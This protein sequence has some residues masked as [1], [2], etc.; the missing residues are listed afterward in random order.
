M[1]FSM[2]TIGGL[3]SQLASGLQGS[4]TANKSKTTTRRGSSNRFVMLFFLTLILVCLGLMAGMYLKVSIQDAYDKEYI[5]LGSELRLL[6]LKLSKEASAAAS[7]QPDA[8]MELTKARDEVRRI[9]KLLEEG[10]PIT[11]MPATPAKAQEALQG[12]QKAWYD[13]LRHIQFITRS[14]Q[15][16]RALRRDVERYRELSAE[17]RNELGELIDRLLASGASPSQVFLATRQLTLTERI[18]K[19]MNRALQ[20]GDKAIAAVNRF[21]R[22]ALLFVNSLEALLAGDKELGVQPIS[23]PT[24]KAIAQKLSAQS[25]RYTRLVN[26]VK[27]NAIA[28]FQVQAAAQAIARTSNLLVDKV[29]TLRDAYVTTIEERTLSTAL[30]NGVGVL[31][32]LILIWMGARMMRDAHVREKEARARE[33]RATQSDQR[34]QSAILRLLDEIGDLADGDL[35]V[36]ASVTEDFTGAIADAINYAVN[37]LRKLVKDINTITAR[38]ASSARGSQATALEL[39]EA[40]E[41]QTKEIMKAT[42]AATEMAKLLQRLS[43]RAKESSE[44]AQS[45][46]EIAGKGSRAVQ[47]TITGMDG[48]REQIQETSKRIKRLG[49]SSQEIGN[50]VGLIDDIADQTNILAL[51]A[52]I[53]ASMAGEAGRGFAVVADEV[54]RL[55]ERSGHATKQIE[56]LV[57]TIQGDAKEAVVSMEQSTAGVVSGA[58]LA[59]GAGQALTAIEKVSTQLADL[60]GDI[61]K[62]TNQQV[63]N[64]TN[65]ASGMST[66]QTV[67]TKVSRETRETAKSVGTVARLADELRTSVHGFRIPAVDVDDTTD[68]AREAG[69]RI[70]SHPVA[71][72][73]AQEAV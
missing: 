32:L 12:F 42:Q 64:A 3:F 2:K 14:Q 73:A 53:Q 9:N 60:I 20:G 28:S 23:D 24:A 59:Q 69:R 19:D 34:N 1:R 49:E 25:G 67:T 63:A 47:D 31:A 48:I 46:V 39:R 8:F 43:T 35:T 70:G 56:E 45:S 15:P 33:E 11:G 68:E 17:V 61:A 58:K 71:Q 18:A 22:D 38:V 6:A 13:T 4:R 44:V 26:E 27:G 54:Q 21:S 5:R 72:A 10:N 37:E 36:Q 16:V 66:I 29:E 50:I 40:T 62:R 55:A 57:K 65:I 41:E 30:A 52:A 7:G 51:N